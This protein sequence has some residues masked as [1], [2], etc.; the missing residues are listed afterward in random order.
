[1]GI[2]GRGFRRVRK[3]TL[4]VDILRTISHSIFKYNRIKPVGK[5]YPF[6]I[7]IIS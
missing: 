5:L 1:M 2:V 7:F 6:I 3:G 4:N